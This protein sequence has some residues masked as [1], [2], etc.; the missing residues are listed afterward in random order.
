MPDDIELVLAQMDGQVTGHADAQ[1]DRANE[2]EASLNVKMALV[3][4][5]SHVQVVTDTLWPD[6]IP[7]FYYRGEANQRL[8]L[9]TIGDAINV[10]WQNR[11]GQGQDYL[12]RRFHE[13]SDLDRQHIIN[14]GIDFQLDPHLEA[15]IHRLAPGASLLDVFAEPV[16]VAEHLNYQERRRWQQ[17]LGGDIVGD[18]PSA[19]KKMAT[20]ELDYLLAV[21]HQLIAYPVCQMLKKRLSW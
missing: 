6:A 21:A 20:R 2:E 11:V 19:T 5:D 3:R 9:G 15:Q 17:Y 8:Q 14:H 18:H 13:L 16:I 12:W 4:V 1:N 7:E 10:D